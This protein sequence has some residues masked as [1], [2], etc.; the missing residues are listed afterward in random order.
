M[1]LCLRC[2]AVVE[3]VKGRCPSCA[4]RTNVGETLAL[5]LQDYEHGLDRRTR[6]PIA[7]T[8]EHD[9]GG[10]FKIVDPAT[11]E[12]LMCGLDTFDAAHSWALGRGLMPTR[13]DADTLKI[14]NLFQ[15]SET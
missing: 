11:G 7:C 5:L 3:P 15:I 8:I 12:A 2:R 10:Y 14:L 4:Q 6:L 9:F 1:N 13:N